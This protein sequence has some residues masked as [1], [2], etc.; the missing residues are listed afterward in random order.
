[1]A[2]TAIVTTVSPPFRGSLRQRSRTNEVKR[3]ERC[4]EQC[5]AEHRVRAE[6]AKDEADRALRS[7]QYKHRQGA[8]HPF[9]A[10]PRCIVTSTLLSRAQ[11]ES[12]REAILQQYYLY[13]ELGGHDR[14]RNLCKLDGVLLVN[15]SL[16]TSLLPTALP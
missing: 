3:A 9:H 2:S 14:N 8:T 15:R 13:G 16:C 10:S 4:E 11:T 1:M 7:I 12:A 5:G 6:E